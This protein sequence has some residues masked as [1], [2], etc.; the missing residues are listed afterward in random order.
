[1]ALAVMVTFIKQSNHIIVSEIQFLALLIV[2]LVML[3]L[4]YRFQTRHNDSSYSYNVE[5][6]ANNHIFFFPVKTC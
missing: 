4:S 6:V 2:N 1:M 5:R 3:E